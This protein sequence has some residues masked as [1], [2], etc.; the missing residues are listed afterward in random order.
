MSLLLL[1]LDKPNCWVVCLTL[2]AVLG[3][4]KK[5]HVMLVHHRTINTSSVNDFR[6]GQS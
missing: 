4:E 1:V 3:E 2:K 5:P 6:K